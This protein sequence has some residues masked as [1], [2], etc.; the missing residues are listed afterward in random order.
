M[1]IFLTKQDCFLGPLPFSRLALMVETTLH[2]KTLS[3]PDPGPFS[4]IGDLVWEPM[5]CL[6][7]NDYPDV[8]W[9]TFEFQARSF[10]T[11]AAFRLVQLVTF[12]I[13]LFCFPST[14]Q[15]KDPPFQNIDFFITINRQRRLV[16]VLQR[17]AV[18]RMELL[19]L[20]LSR[21]LQHSVV[22]RVSG[23]R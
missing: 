15:G 8:L 6:V 3:R 13:L 2:V 9:N 11:T 16:E 21:T 20:V 12:S 14:W 1:Y 10:C 18:A 4:A 7:V 19:R 22:V 5:E 17:L 23:R